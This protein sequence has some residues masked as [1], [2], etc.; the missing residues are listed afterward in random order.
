MFCYNLSDRR[1][2]CCIFGKLAEVLIQ[3]QKQPNNGDIC[4]IRYAKLNNYTHGI[5]N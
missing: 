3:E 5:D 1:V 2:R 4:L